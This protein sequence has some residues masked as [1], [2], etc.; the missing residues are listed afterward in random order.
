MRSVW[1][2]LKRGESNSSYRS[3]ALRRTSLKQVQTP[4]T[5]LC[6]PDS[7]ES[8]KAGKR[9]ISAERRSPFSRRRLHGQELSC[10]TGRL[11]SLLFRISRVG[12]DKSPQ[13]LR[14]Q[15]QRQSSGAEI[16]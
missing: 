1:S 15:T 4:G 5:R 6:C 12:R 16:P 9:L 10:G 8:L 2:W 11:E 13:P 7:K 14:N 3:T